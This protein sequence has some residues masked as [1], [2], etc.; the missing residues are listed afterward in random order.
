MKIT[1]KLYLSIAKFHHNFES[2]AK[3]SRRQT[4]VNCNRDIRHHSRQTTA[5]RGSNEISRRRYIEIPN[6]AAR[7]HDHQFLEFN[8][9]LTLLYRSALSF[10]PLCSTRRKPRRLTDVRFASKWVNGINTAR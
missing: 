10:P 7:L 2:R 8:I 9:R 1:G 3:V 4:V 6:F 5:S